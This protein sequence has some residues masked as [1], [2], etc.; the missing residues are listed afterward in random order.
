MNKY[1]KTYLQTI[2]IVIIGFVFICSLYVSTQTHSRAKTENGKVYKALHIW[3]PGYKIDYDKDIFS[4]KTH[5]R[6][7]PWELDSPD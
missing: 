4:W 1:L 3:L 5:H 6:I 2:T 7:G